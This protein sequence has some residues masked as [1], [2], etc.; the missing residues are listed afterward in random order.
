MMY[1]SLAIMHCAMSTLKAIFNPT[2]CYM[3]VVKS[4][5]NAESTKPYLLL[6]IEWFTAKAGEV[7]GKGHDMLPRFIQDD[8]VVKIA[9]QNR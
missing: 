2:A 5:P 3:G 4:L 9:I 7:K 1:S 6:K 8:L